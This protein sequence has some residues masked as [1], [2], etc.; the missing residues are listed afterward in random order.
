[1]SLLTATFVFPE[2][3]TRRNG[4]RFLGRLNNRPNS[5][6]TYQPGRGIL[7]AMV[8]GGSG[9]EGTVRSPQ[10]WNEDGNAAL[11]RKR[12]ALLVALAVIT[13][14]CVFLV[15]FNRTI[16]VAYHHW[17]ME[18]AYGS[19]FGNPQP[20]GN[21]L[22]AFEVTAPDIDAAIAAYESHRQK[23]VDI[24]AL[25]HAQAS[26][27]SVALADNEGHSEA[28]SAFVNRMWRKFPNHRHYWL[29]PDGTFEAWIPTPD[30]QRWQQFLDGE[31]KSLGVVSDE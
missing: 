18:A 4:F 20:I 28:R 27:P 11:S 14:V 26:F 17:R 13:I 24:G 12:V 29:R 1:M 21:G 7:R 2:S 23:L 9:Q 3:S 22:A 31:T 25:G 19:L 10:E 30:E 16:V 6:L 15:V 8:G 5:E